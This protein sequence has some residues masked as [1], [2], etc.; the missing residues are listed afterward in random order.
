MRRP[1]RSSFCSLVAVLAAVSCGDPQIRGGGG[2]GNGNNGGGVSPERP[3]G[4]SG[5]S[6]TS[7]PAPVGGKSGA[8]TPR[9]SR[10]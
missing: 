10:R 1:S 2:N 9:F 4:G 3:G 8:A 5:G 6:G 7:S